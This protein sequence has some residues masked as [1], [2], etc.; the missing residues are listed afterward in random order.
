MVDVQA[1]INDTHSNPSLYHLLTDKHV[2]YNVFNTA[3]SQI[4]QLLSF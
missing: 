2:D 4:Y 1:I 3:K